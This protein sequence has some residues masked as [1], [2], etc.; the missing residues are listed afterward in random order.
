VEWIG[1]A[2]DGDKWRAVVNAV[3]KFRVP[4]NVG[5]LSSVQTTGGLFSSAEKCTIH[6]LITKSDLSAV[7]RNTFGVYSENHTKPS[8]TLCRAL[9]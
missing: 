4:Y 1:L 2:H 8:S 3:M 9:E 5:K 7:C 6:I